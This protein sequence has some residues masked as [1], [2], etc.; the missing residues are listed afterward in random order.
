VALSQQ[1]SIA[2]QPK[3]K[4]THSHPVLTAAWSGDGSA[5]FSGGSDNQIKMWNLGAAA[6]GGSATQEVVVAQHAA[7]I[8]S[9]HHVTEMGVIVTGSYDKTI[10]Y[11]DLRQSNPVA[12]IQ[13]NE[14]VYAMDVKYPVLAVATATVPENVVDRG[15]QKV[16]KKNK[17]FIYNLQG[18]PSQPFRTVD[19]PLKFQHR[20]LEIFPDK[21]GFAVGSVEGRVAISHVQEKDLPRNFAFK[22]HRQGDEI[23]AVNAISFHPYGTFA[24]AGSDGV[25][26]FWDKDAKQRLK[27]FSRSPNGITAA[28]FNPAGNIYA[29]ALGYDWSKG[30]E[31][32]QR[33]KDPC[34]IMLHATPDA[35]IAKKNVAK[36]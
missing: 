35:E 25:Y 3:A 4:V 13:L 17:V 27:L 11:W 18:N 31:Y 8:K 20:C 28:T 22:C 2:T 29:Y 10:K 12:S 7:P 23:Y 9:V 1:G 16:E 33:Q 26:T 21:T 5:I 24:T 6:G 15:V 36:K 32:Y 34:T 14:R 19:S 30:V